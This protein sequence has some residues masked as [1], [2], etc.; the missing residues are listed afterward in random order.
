M[1]SD[2]PSINNIPSV[3]R[4]A[5]SDF[6]VNLKKIPGPRNAQFAKKRTMIRKALHQDLFGRLIAT[7]F[8][9]T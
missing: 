1:A 6:E 7:A 2:K 8:S 9:L 3:V 5:F 4:F